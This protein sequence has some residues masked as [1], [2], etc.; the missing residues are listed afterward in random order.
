M[1]RLWSDLGPIKNK[2][3]WL[4]VYSLLS[5]SAA[6]WH[7]INKIQLGNSSLCWK[8]L[9]FS[10]WN[11]CLTVYFYQRQQIMQCVFGNISSWQKI[12]FGRLRIEKCMK[13]LGMFHVQFNFLIVHWQHSRFREK[14]EVLSAG[15]WIL[16]T[17]PFCY[18][19]LNS[20]TCG[21][22]RTI[23][24]HMTVLPINNRAK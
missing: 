9:I 16:I 6:V 19:R 5:V 13:Q 22:T 7:D 24:H 10:Y 14:F 1:G 20:F 4:F 8:R 21:G 2:S 11:E 3:F 17:H 12:S 18:F 23:C 15:P